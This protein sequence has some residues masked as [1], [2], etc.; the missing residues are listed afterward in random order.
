MAYEWQKWPKGDDTIADDYI[1]Q[2]FEWIENF[3]NSVDVYMRNRNATT[4]QEMAKRAKIFTDNY[5]SIPRDYFIAYGDWGVSQWIQRN[6]FVNAYNNLVNGVSDFNSD[7]EVAAKNADAIKAY[8]DN[9]ESYWRSCVRGWQMAPIASAAVKNGW[10]ATVG[11]EKSAA[12]RT[13][14]MTAEQ[15][16]NHLLNWVYNGNKPF[17]NTDPV[18][19]LNTAITWASQTIAPIAWPSNVIV[20]T[21]GNVVADVP[22]GVINTGSNGAGSGAM[23]TVKKYLPLALV[24]GVAYLAMR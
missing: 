22:G 15:L 21:D 20:G 11:F 6:V 16:K 5:A 1:Q 14:A 12:G 13:P 7:D 4:E 24:A 10:N 8:T 19:I 3:K 18:Q 23:D 17:A 9:N 2:G